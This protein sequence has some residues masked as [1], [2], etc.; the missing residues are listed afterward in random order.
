MRSPARDANGSISSR[1]FASLKESENR[2]P[3]PKEQSA[4][5]LSRP[6]EV[7]TVIRELATTHNWALSDRED[8]ETPHRLSPR[9]AIAKSNR[10]HD[11]G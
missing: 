1:R 9:V 5:E 8:F 6:R 3:R 7:G 4:H 2:T 11:P 10:L